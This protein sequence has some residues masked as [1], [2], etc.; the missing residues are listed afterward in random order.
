M[1]YESK[2]I[3]RY[4][5][6]PLIKLT[7]DVDQGILDY[8]RAMLPKAVRLNLQRYNA[9]ISVVRKEI[10]PNM[11]VWGK[12]EGQ[13][14]DFQY[15]NVVYNGA[16]YYW[17]NA[18]S[19]RLEEIRIELGLLVDSPFTRPPD[20]LAKTFHMTLGNTKQLVQA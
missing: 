1:L 4:S 2:G 18:F 15:E 5:I 11:D 7:V 8:Y 9:H 12:H 16:V 19:K 10:P 6:V 17:L 20:G 14:V 3:L 13:E